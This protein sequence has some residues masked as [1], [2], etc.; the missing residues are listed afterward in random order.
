MVA[1]LDTK[2][3]RKSNAGGSS[4]ESAG[5]DRGLSKVRN[6]GVIAHI[7]A[8]KTTTTER[9]L[10]Y[11]G[12]VHKVGEVHDGT[13]VM[14]YMDQERERGITITSAATTCFWKE[15]QV[16]IIDTPGHVDF[17]VE[18][19]R[20]LRILDGAVGVFCG[21][22]GVQPQSET[23]W[24]QADHYQV[25]RLAFVNKMDRMGADFARVVEEMRS[26][27]GSNAVPVQLPWGCEA[28]F[29]GVIDLL[30][31]R[32]IRFDSA[33]MG[34]DMVQEPIPTELGADAERARAELVEQVAEKDE[35][36]LELYLE[37]PDVPADVLRGGLRRVTLAGTMV[38]VLCGSALRNT[39]VQP[40]MDAVV[41]F[42][43]SP[44]DV[45]DIVGVHTKSG[46][47]VAFAADDTAPLAALVFKVVNDP[48]MG[49][50]AFVRVYS[51]RIKKGQNVFNPRLHQ[52]ERVS[53][54][55][56]LHADD[57]TDTDQL[58][59]GEIGAVVGLKNFT[60]GDTL[61]L[62]NLPAELNRIRFPEPVIFMA[63]EPKSSADR[64]KLN[65]SLESLSAE[66]PTCIVQ[67]DAETGQKVI[68]G[69]G[70]LHLDII[71]E[72]L[73]REYKVVANT[74]KP[75]VAFHE[76]ITASARA[77]H[78]FDREIGGGRQL[79]H[80]VLEI[81]PAERRSGNTI[82]FDVSTTRIPEV[83][84]K[85]IEGGLQDGLMTGV[86]ARYPLVDMRVRV[87]DGS[88]DSE[89]STDVA[90]RSAAVLA[91]REAVLAA[92]PEFLE[93]IM[94]LDI[95]TPAETMGDVMG[96]ISARRGKV[97]GMETRGDLQ[98]IQAGVPLA[99]LFGYST[100]IRSLTKGRATYTME[101]QAF[102][103]V[104][105]TI[106]QELLNK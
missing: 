97:K 1:T 31:M 74:G 29:C 14:D 18:V 90:F 87:V 85:D 17:T 56:R 61:C 30:E 16:N 34:R 4:R 5:R 22:G 38:P 6:I 2:K 15:C 75:M 83:Y 67:E 96:D 68:S 93:P 77:E 57:R 50:T 43:P 36:V 47:E 62:E 41:E 10:Y 32:A 79:G 25:P 55:L 42:L 73:K 27:L 84:R 64:D 86:L 98:I 94:A 104:P 35:E 24:R 8:G 21:V 100:A 33:S 81:E 58:Y 82:E 9:M 95:I 44:L 3:N 40:L 51:G 102:A 49:R 92:G 12:R 19:E 70:E 11:A 7:D 23:V 101:P 65:E 28:T 53:R 20:S 105:T 71:V 91:L 63:I 78:R 103:I 66:D 69:M 52:R 76:T 54:L 99:Q 37:N 39:G 26:K 45:A 80:V 89:L 106:K 72:R 60:T 88:F 59:S 48:Y 13:A 46:D